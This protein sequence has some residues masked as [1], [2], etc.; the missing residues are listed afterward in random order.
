M[1]MLGPTSGLP[2]HIPYA[3]LFHLDHYAPLFPLDLP[4]LAVTVTG[5]TCLCIYIPGPIAMY[6]PSLDF[7]GFH[8][9]PLLCRTC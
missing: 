7:S 6:L 2:T 4:H 8:A 5:P 3:I 1:S 9:E